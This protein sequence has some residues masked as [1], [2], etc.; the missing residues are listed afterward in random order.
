MLPEMLEDPYVEVVL[1]AP[2]SPDYIPGPEE[3]EQA[4]PS[5]DYVPGLEHADDEI[6]AE[7]QPY[8]EDA[9]P[10]AQSPEYIP[11]SDFEA[12]PENDDDED[13]ED[14]PVD[15]SANGGDDSDDEEE[16]SEDEEDDEM[17]ETEPFETDEFAATPPPH[18]AYRTTARISIPA[19]VPRP[20]WSD[21]EVARLLAIS[22]P[23]ASPLSLW[24]SPPPQIPFPRLPPILSPP[25]PFTL[26]LITTTSCLR[27]LDNRKYKEYA[28][29]LKM[30][31]KTLIRHRRGRFFTNG[32]D[33]LEL[34]SIALPIV[35]LCELGNCPQ[36]TSFMGFVMKMGFAGLWLGLLATQGSC[37]LL[38]LYVLCKTDWIIQVKEVK[39]L[40]K[41]PSSSTA[42]NL[43]L[44]VSNKNQNT[45]PSME[46]NNEN[47]IMINSLEI[48]SNDA[49]ATQQ[50]NSFALTVGKR[51]S[52]GTSSGNALEHFIAL[53]VAKYS[54][55]RIFIT[56]SGNDLDHFIPNIND[57]GS[58]NSS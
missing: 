25:S 2:T 52:S 47:I 43:V 36:T 23:P 58:T 32:L 48:R 4:P 21:S 16:S 10:I 19:P 51:T 54:S 50:W 31:F 37:A 18:P 45:K 27:I 46:A 6:V 17:D 55:S 30:L 1:Q 15:Y 41:S 5:P 11:E 38:M 56:G 53:T 8:A 9:S 24:S 42:N 49:M 7:D 12:H 44:L 13:P 57:L 22:S 26:P 28:G 40:T 34:T 33:I 29:L 39:E 20:A 35:G 14:D 3:P